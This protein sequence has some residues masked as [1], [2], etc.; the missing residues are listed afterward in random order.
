[1]KKYKTLAGMFSASC[2]AANEHRLRI[3]LTYHTS[4]T[5]TTAV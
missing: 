4:W 3:E 5:L 1:V 2:P